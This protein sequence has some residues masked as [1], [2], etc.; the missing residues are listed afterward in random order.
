MGGTGWITGETIMGAGPA[1]PSAAI[2]AARANLDPVVIVGLG[3][4]VALHHRLS[5]P[6]SLR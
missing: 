1:G 5:I 4:I 6:D 2:Y 3:R